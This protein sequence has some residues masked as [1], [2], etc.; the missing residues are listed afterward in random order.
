MGVVGQHR[1]ISHQLSAV[2]HEHASHN[3]LTRFNIS[4]VSAGR[5]EVG[6]A[7]TPSCRCPSW[8]RLRPRLAVAWRGGEEGENGSRLSDSRSKWLCEACGFAASLWFAVP[9][10]PSLEFGVSRSASAGES[11]LVKASPGAGHR[12]QP[13][14]LADIEHCTPRHPH[15]MT[16][17]TMCG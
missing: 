8:A 2:S 7:W 5:R 12:S 17:R 16:M 15:T 4:D 14:D 9:K 10:G 3:S 6:A 1:W 11:V 13:P